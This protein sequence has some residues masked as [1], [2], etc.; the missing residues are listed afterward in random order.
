MK[1]LEPMIAEHPFMAGLNPHF[2]HLFNECATFKRYGPGQEIFHEHLSADHFYLIKH[3]SVALETFAPGLGNITI[4][5]IHTGDALGWSWLFPP[6][7]WKFTARSTDASELIAFGAA[8]LREKA[9]ENAAFGYDLVMRV[10]K[11]LSE[12]LQAT[13]RQLLDFYADKR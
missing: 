11:V 13:R 9:E 7:T 1:T 3:G 5:T 10:A 8:S 2:L 6:Y 12:R 4:Q